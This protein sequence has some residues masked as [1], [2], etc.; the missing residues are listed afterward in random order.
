MEKHLKARVKQYRTSYHQNL[1]EES[2]QLMDMLVVQGNDVHVYTASDNQIKI[3]VAGGGETVKL[4]HRGC[5][6]NTVSPKT[7][8]PYGWMYEMDYW[9]PDGT[10]D[11]CMDWRAA[12]GTTPGGRVYMP[13]YNVGF[14]WNPVANSAEEEKAWC[15]NLNNY[16]E[17]N[18]EG[19]DDEKY[20]QSD[21]MAERFWAWPGDG[22]PNVRDNL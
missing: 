9:C 10:I 11:S 6:I 7:G 21:K 15:E 18:F 5:W 4:G 1:V 12:D 17:Q 14:H 16:L 2:D 13:G 8:K 20:R 22:Y 19:D 3:N